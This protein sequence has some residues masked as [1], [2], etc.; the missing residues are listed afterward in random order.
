MLRF[1]LE[2]VVLESR[3]P[4]CAACPLPLRCGTTAARRRGEV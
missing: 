3:S 1:R 4:Y 2:A